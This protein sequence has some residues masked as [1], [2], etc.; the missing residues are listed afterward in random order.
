MTKVVNL[1]K[2]KYDVYIGRPSKFGNPY[3]IGK[4]GAREDVLRK[5]GIYFYNKLNSDDNFAREVI[6]LKDK[7]LGCFC[8]PQ[9]CHG[10]IIVEFL[11]SLEEKS[12]N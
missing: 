1:R 9:R 5:Y 7:T 11:N 3:I 4:D 6:D 8:R 10:D 12:E 2:E